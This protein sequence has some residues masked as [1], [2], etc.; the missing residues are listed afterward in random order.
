MPDKFLPYVAGFLDGDGCIMLQLV[1]RHDYVFGYQIRAS[2]V[3]YQKTKHKDFLVWLK[4]RLRFGYI[5]DRN[6]D[7]TEYT[8]VGFNEVENILKL[9][10]PYI[11][12]K[13][14]QTKLA[15]QIIKKLKAVKRYTPPILLKVSKLVDQFAKLNYSK[16]RT[17]TSAKVEAYLK[18]K[19]LLSP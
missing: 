6:D 3:F 15:L 9:L 10:Q 2:I 16:K 12:L 7:I 1:Y 8:I 4:K 14:N 11:R 18:A 19:D 5:R 13:K 17:N